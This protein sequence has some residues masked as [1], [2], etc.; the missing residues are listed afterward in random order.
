VEG[1][2]YIGGV[3]VG[4]GYLVAGA[5]LGRLSV[6]TRKTP[7]GLLAVAFVLWGLSYVC[8]QIPLIF[9]NESLFVPLYTA[10]RLLTDA[11]TVGAA[12][13]LRRV[14]R[15][16][17]RLATGLVAGITVG[18]SLGI[19]GSGSMGDWA[20]LD[21]LRNPWWW[22]E[23]SAV[24][25]S[26]G[27]IGVEG[28]HHYGMSKRRLRLGLCSSLDCSRY[29][30]WGLTGAVWMVYELAYAIQQI[31]FQASGVFSASLDGIASAL[32]TIPII[33]IWLIFFPPASYKRWLARS[34]SHPTVV[35][36]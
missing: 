14:F 11:G 8:W 22:L 10:G 9:E 13:F 34:D 30:L 17:S 24:V 15:P 6:K 29:L 4:L 33:F 36:G 26:V 28:F 31:E 20:S 25:V 12:F 2:A 21:P 19:A 1:S 5:R 16:A 7:E 32:E 3:I 18:L 27:W 35:E 23:W